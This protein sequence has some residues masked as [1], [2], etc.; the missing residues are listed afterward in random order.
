MGRMPSFRSAATLGFRL[1]KSIHTSSGL[2]QVEKSPAISRAVFSLDP[3]YEACQEVFEGGTNGERGGRGGARRSWVHQGA[4][5]SSCIQHRGHAFL[6]I[7]GVRSAGEE[8]QSRDDGCRAGLACVQRRGDG[9]ATQEAG[10]KLRA[11]GAGVR[12]GEAAVDDRR[13]EGGRSD[14]EALAFGVDDLAYELLAV[15]GEGGAASS[16]PDRR[17]RALASAP[18]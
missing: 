15:G 13:S 11:D 8:R 1:S 7:N 4:A 2:S 17:E 16:R 18:W 12:A 10:D 3:L 9:A 6:R 14:P 5:R